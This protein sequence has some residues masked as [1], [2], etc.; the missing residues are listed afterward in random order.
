MA[1]GKAILSQWFGVT[2][3]II[4]LQCLVSDDQHSNEQSARGAYNISIHQSSRL[5]GSYYYPIFDL[6]INV[7]NSIPL[8]A[9]SQQ[10]GNNPSPGPL[11]S[12]GGRIACPS[13][14]NPLLDYNQMMNGTKGPSTQPYIGG[15]VLVGNYN[16]FNGA[17]KKGNG[18]QNNVPM[19]LLL[20]LCFGV[21]LVIWKR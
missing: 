11:D 20:L 19:V 8:N 5:N 9:S 6:P 10:N 15:P 12:N 13:L 2:T 18:S 4:L 1:F 7:S 21:N 16:G 17:P 3:N 14:E